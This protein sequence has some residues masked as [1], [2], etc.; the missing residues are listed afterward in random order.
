MVTLNPAKA[1]Q[2]DDRLEELLPVISPMQSRIP[3]S[4]G[5]GMVHDAIVE[6][7]NSIEWMIIDGKLVK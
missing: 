1:L 2:Q 5:A 3:Y 4:G 6:N 7:R